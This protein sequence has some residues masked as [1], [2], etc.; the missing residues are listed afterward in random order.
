M[1][2]EISTIIIMNYCGRQTRAARLMQINTETTVY[3][4]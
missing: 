3:Y 2:G 4:M 1:A